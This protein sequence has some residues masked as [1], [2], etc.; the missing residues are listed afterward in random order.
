LVNEFFPPFQPWNRLSAAV[1]GVIRSRIAER[2]T[3][4]HTCKAV[5]KKQPTNLKPSTPESR[6]F[7][8]SWNIVS[9]LRPRSPAQLRTPFH[10]GITAMLMSMAS[11]DIFLLLNILINNACGELGVFDNNSIVA[12]VSGSVYL[13]DSCDMRTLLLHIA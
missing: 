4:H 3:L 1:L 12:R 5:A 7:L 10:G 9:R 8:P 11:K 6:C 2:C 13:M